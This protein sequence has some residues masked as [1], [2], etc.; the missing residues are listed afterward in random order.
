[1]TPSCGC[2]VKKPLGLF[3]CSQC[4]HSFCAEQTYM[5]VDESTLVLTP[6]YHCESCHGGDL[7]MNPKRVWHKEPPPYIGWWNAS[8]AQSPSVWR[9]W[10]GKHWSLATEICAS[11]YQV[12]LFSSNRTRIRGIEWTDY[13]PKNARVPMIKP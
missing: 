10:N 11:L 8:A 12:K 5:F 7:P 4:G 2:E 6:K 9:W 13:H 3:K 1:M